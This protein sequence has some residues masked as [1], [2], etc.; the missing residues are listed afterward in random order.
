MSASEDEDALAFLNLVNLVTYSD[1]SKRRFW[2][3]PFWRA[4][5]KKCG[6]FNVFKEL[7]MYQEKFQSFYRMRKE[8]F[9]LLLRKIEPAISKTHDYKTRT[10]GRNK[11]FLG[12][13]PPALES[14][15]G[16]QKG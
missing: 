9:Q 10:L 8:T 11:S 4:N 13:V 14:P 3:H 5:V 1:R 6:A 15:V 7:N 12:N 16:A 2:V